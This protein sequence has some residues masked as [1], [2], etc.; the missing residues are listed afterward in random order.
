MQSSKSLRL[1][2]YVNLLDLQV[3]NHD[4]D[5]MVLLVLPLFK[6]VVGIPLVGLLAITILKK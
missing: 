3:L 4:E 2:F 1:D 6:S 5:S